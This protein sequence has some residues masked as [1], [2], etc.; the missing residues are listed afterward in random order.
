[1]N[2]YLNN[3]FS[4]VPIYNEF[5]EKYV[6]KANHSFI[7]IYIYILKKSINNE[8]LILSELSQNL[9]MLASDILRGISYWKEEGLLDYEEIDEKLK[10]TFFDLNSNKELQNIKNT[11]IS[12]NDLDAQNEIT[13]SENL[14][15]KSEQSEIK[16]LYSLAEKKLAKT[17]SYNEKQILTKLY[18]EYGMS[19]EIMATLFTYCVEKRKLNF[20]YI[21]KV[22][23]DWHENNIDSIEKLEAYLDLYDKN[24]KAIL[25]A[26][27]I[28]NRASIKEEED[29][30]KKWLV[31]LNMPLE[32]IKFCCTRTIMNTGYNRF[33]YADK[34]IV[35]LY[36]KNIKT[37]EE[38]KKVFNEFDREFKNKN[39]KEVPINYNKQQKN[40]FFNYKQTEYDHE[41]IKKMQF[42]LL[43]ME[44][45]EQ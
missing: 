24:Y 21:E 1:M 6:S 38:A 17:L 44:V 36:E 4:F 13:T 18:S 23:I 7:I 33:S 42:E 31:D 41:K 32:I 26:F 5:I 43:K 20:S 25:K 11:D 40:K 34:I 15:M 35:G 37:I 27:G 30:M 39:N 19:I 45:G 12:F 3:Y 22:A 8:M 9:N 14:L 16:Q 2:N 29:Y 10:V 28:R